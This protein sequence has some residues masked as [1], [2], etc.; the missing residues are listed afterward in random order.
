MD[1]GLAEAAGRSPWLAEALAAER[2]AEPLPLSGRTT[3]DVCIVG[4]G[5]TGLWTALELKARQ[6]DLDVCLIEARLCGSGASGTNAGMLMNLW[7]KFA[8]LQA[9][10]SRDHAVWLAQQS[11]AAVEDVIEFCHDHGIDAHIER[12]G[13]LWASSSQ[14]QDGSWADSMNLVE[15]LDGVPF[16]VLDGDA[17]S[18]LG[19]A[20]LRGGVLDPTAATLDPALLVRGLRRVAVEQYGVRVYENS[21]MKATEER[22][23]NT[24]VVTPAGH[25]DAGTVVLAINAWMSTFAAA[26]KTMLISASDNAITRRL[27]DELLTGAGEAGM[28]VSDSTRML[29]YWRTTSDG[30]VVFGKGGVGLGFGQR[31]ARSMFGPVP[32][33]Q[34]IRRGFDRLLPTLAGEAFITTWRAPVEY[35]LTSL[36]YFCRL[37]G[38]RRVWF[39]TGY[40]GDG[41]GPSRMGGRILASLALG[42]DDEWSNCAFT[43]APRGWL[44]PEPFRFLGGQLVRQAMINKERAENAGR[45]PG[46]VVAA[47]SRLDPT[48]WV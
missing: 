19:S 6:P 31:G 21:P 35:T 48:T 16:Q 39:G 37:P 18:A 34:L 40:S 7:P 25:V 13:W 20:T 44:P 8:S 23:N 43:Q 2:P 42:Q 27:P 17:A 29:N 11:A 32:R 9:L 38:R 30:R 22:G 36:P 28:G 1:R 4:G 12:R 26:R 3:A 5:F 15:G 46:R 41:V 10:A 47:L 33:E 24:L 45:Q 14:A